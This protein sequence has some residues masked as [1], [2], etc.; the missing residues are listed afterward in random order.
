MFTSVVG[1]VAF[2]AGFVVRHFIPLLVA[3]FKSHA[4][5]KA[6]ADAKALVA[7]AEADAAA[8]DSAKKL[9]AAQPVKSA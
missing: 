5:S 9:V 3:W 8:L 4:A 1:V 6:L 7:K 2:A